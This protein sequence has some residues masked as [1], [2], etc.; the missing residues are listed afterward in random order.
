MFRLLKVQ[1]LRL[2][3]LTEF[4]MRSSFTS[5]FQSLTLSIP[6]LQGST[7]KFQLQD[8]LIFLVNYRIIVDSV[9]QW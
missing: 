6:R 1:L 7:L 3:Q 2:Q 5:L 9:S 4:K 8:D